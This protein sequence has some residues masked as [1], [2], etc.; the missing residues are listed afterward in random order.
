MI[1]AV[2]TQFDE[3]ISQIQMNKTDFDPAKVEI[4]LQKLNNVEK[5][6]KTVFEARNVKMNLLQQQNLQL[7]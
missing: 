4:L 1:N 5:D 2:K 6:F 7:E 3:G